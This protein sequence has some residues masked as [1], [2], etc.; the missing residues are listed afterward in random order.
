MSRIKIKVCGLRDP[1]N[2]RQIAELKP[3]L[4]GLIFYPASPR[5]VGETPAKGL[6]ESFPPGIVKTGVFVDSDLYN[7][8]AYV[9]RFGLKAVQLHGNESPEICK[10]LMATGVKVIKA[11]KISENPDFS[12]MMRYVSHCNWFLFDTASKNH[13]GSGKSFDWNIL[14]NYDIGHPFFLSGGI[15]P[16]DAAKIL[17]L[18][19]PALHGVDINSRFETEAGIKDVEKVKR[20]IRTIRGFKNI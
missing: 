18:K 6:L 14:D 13:G 4:T 11:F 12:A 15:G 8:K 5:Y 1:E 16:G 9:M 3:D 10:Q 20:F 17:Q 2:I 19:H 7:I